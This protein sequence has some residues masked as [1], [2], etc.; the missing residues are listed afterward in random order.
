MQT[1]TTSERFLGVFGKAA[2]SV[3]LL[4][5][6]YILNANNQ[7]QYF[8]WYR[9]TT[10]LRNE[11]NAYKCIHFNLKCMHLYAYKI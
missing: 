6:L 1:V 7:K 11:Q 8:G 2:N 10:Q 4:E 5:S 3:L 9:L